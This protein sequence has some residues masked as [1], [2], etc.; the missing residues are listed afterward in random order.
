MLMTDSTNTEPESTFL[1]RSLEALARLREGWRP[2]G[3]LLATAR[4]AEYWRVIR[5]DDTT[6]FQFIG[7]P[8][9]SPERSSM[10]IATV[11]AMDPAAGWA[12]LAGGEWIRIGEQL[13]A[14]SPLEPADLAKCA[15]SWLLMGAH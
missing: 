14:Q 2:D 5:R 10:F 3:N 15:E 12:L 7:F 6:G 9:R 8:P 4:Y 13:P 11:L 1:D